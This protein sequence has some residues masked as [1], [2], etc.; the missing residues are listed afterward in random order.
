MRLVFLGTPAIAATCL[1][2][3]IADGHEI[4]GVY[5]KPDTP[6][7]RG[8][9]LQP[10]EVKVVALAH[11]LAVFQPETFRDDA[12]VEELQALQPELIACVAYGK[13]LPQRVLDIPP[14]GCV[15]IHASI[16]PSLRGAGPIQWSI[17][18]GDE[19]TG[20]TAMY[21]AKEMD[22]GDIIEITRT[23]ID[24]FETGE[25][26]TG[27]LAELGA[28]LL[29]KTVKD[30]ENGIIHRT[31]QDHGKAT[32]A[33]MLTKELS[34]IDWSRTQRQIIDQ[35]RGLIPWP[36]AT[37]E[38]AGKRFKIFRVEPVEDASAAAPG[39]L[40]QLDKQGL[41]VA[42]GDGALRI[43][44]LQAEGGK[45]MSA[46]DYFRGHPIELG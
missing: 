18:N 46:A 32:F 36:V 11:G 25:E 17:L 9:K 22:A 13:I 8:M 27:R 44:Q 4:V 29:S 16:L 45:R 2:R 3:L 21:M 42:C 30:I 20:V 23:P 39:T 19:E 38:L 12:A 26:L 1:E 40:L 34:P 33:P 6:K 7:N 28:E 5:T 24:P 41:I 35:V 10:S 37:C 31:P 43:T 14:L 15:N